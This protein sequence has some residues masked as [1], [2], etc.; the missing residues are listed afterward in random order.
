[1]KKGLSLLANTQAV[2]TRKESSYRAI[3]IAKQPIGIQQNGQYL[4]SQNSICRCQG[5]VSLANQGTVWP[6]TIVFPLD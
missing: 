4:V 1:M 6:I 5:K 2:R 3:F